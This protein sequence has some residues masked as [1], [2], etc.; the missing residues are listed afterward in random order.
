[1]RGYFV[2]NGVPDDKTILKL[3]ELF[4]VEFDVGK[5][6]FINTFQTRHPDKKYR[7]YDKNKPRPIPP[8]NTKLRTYKDNFWSRLRVEK[9]ISAKELAKLLGLNCK[10]PSELYNWCSGKHIPPDKHI[11]KFC[12]IYD[13]DYEKG[14]Q[15]FINA[16]SQWYSW[17]HDIKKA[18][19]YTETQELYH[20]EKKTFNEHIPEIPT[21]M[22]VEQSKL[23]IRNKIFWNKIPPEIQETIRTRI[24][25]CKDQI[26][27][28]LYGEI[29]FYTYDIIRNYLCKVLKIEESD[30]GETN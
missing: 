24:T 7:N 19:I 1:M 26:L 4:M 27:N 17:D 6:Q 16:H 28:E 2:G 8:P 20:P 18:C 25:D 23:N 12:E 5:E 30:L 3:C 9:G 11:R 15:E 22:G 14:K 13:V 29:D 10:N 21:D